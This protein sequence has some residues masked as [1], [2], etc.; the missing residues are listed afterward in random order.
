[1]Q[2]FWTQ[3]AFTVIIQL[4]QSS[5]KN[6]KAKATL[7]KVMLKIF[8]LISLMYAGD[9]DFNPQTTAAYQAKKLQ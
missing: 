5:I 9:E 2:D 8:G 4:L 6:A 3:I 7:K 1:M